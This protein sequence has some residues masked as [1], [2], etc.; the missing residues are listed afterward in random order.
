MGPVSGPDYHG[1]VLEL[2]SQRWTTETELPGHELWK[3][4]LTVIV[5]DKVS[6]DKAFLYITGG[7]NSDPAPTKA[8]DRF[9]KL[10]VETNSVVVELDDVPNQP[11]TFADDPAHKARVEDEI[12]A[13]QQARYAKTRDPDQL[14]RLPMVKSGW[15]R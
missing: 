1:A 8:V 10:A 15:P 3:H 14:L 13:Y 9:A 11:L 2:T 7:K 4:W 12:I 5:P 6:H